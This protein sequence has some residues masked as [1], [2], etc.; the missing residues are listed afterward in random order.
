MS[1]ADPIRWRD[2]FRSYIPPWLSD[3]PGRNAGYRFL[4]S[5]I[6]PLDGLEEVLFQG[7]RSKF[8]GRGTPT[9]LP[10][11][12]RSRGILRSQ[13]ETDESYSARL[14]VWLDTHRNAGSAEV[15]ARSIHDYLRSHPM[16]RVVNRAGSWVTIAADGTMTKT[17]AAWNWDGTSHPSRAGFWSEFWVI[18]YAGVQWPLRAGSLGTL[19]GADG[20]ALGHMATIEEVDAVRGL[21]AQWKGAHSRCR[22]LI[23]T[24][25]LTR[26]DPATPSSLPDGTWGAWGGTGSGSRTASG[27]DLTTCRFWEF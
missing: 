5:M 20:Y 3:R 25:D 9:A 21:L 16:V 1:D 24:T 12:G 10:L 13:D 8:P 18:V 19:T 22:A 26:F 14:A 17:S 2:I 7:A 11:V 23:A 15:I 27:R 6:A 4:W